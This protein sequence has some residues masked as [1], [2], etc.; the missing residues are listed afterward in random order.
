[1]LDEMERGRLC[2]DQVCDA[3]IRKDT[4]P[5]EMTCRAVCPDKNNIVLGLDNGSAGVCEWR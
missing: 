4:F 2:G 3:V 1:M 5:I